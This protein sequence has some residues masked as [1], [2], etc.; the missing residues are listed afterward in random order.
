MNKPLIGITLDYEE[1]G[2]YSKFP[3]YAIRENYLSC[4]Y[5]FNAIPFPLF[6]EIESVSEICKLIDGLILTGGNFDINPLTYGNKNTKSRTI[7]SKRTNF[8]IKIFN[9]FFNKKKPILGIC[10][11]EQL[12]NVA[13]GGNLIQDIKDKTDNLINHEQLNPRNQT[14]HKIN[15]IKG[16]KTSNIINKKEIMVN[17]AHHQA[18]HRLGKNLV[19]TAIAEDNI[20]EGIEHTNH[21]WCIGVQW[22]PEFL[23]TNEDRLIINDFIYNSSFDL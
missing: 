1:P 6:H 22:H 5:K 9:E 23:I 13:C 7:K 14:S 21:P 11:G 18:V 17:S 10:G 15:L 20:I 3:W 4:I 12:I 8:E 16:T 2:N 19:K